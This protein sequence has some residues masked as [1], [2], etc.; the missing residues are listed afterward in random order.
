MAEQE[1]RRM[2]ATYLAS[3]VACLALSDFLG[4][5]AELDNPV[6]RPLPRRTF[7]PDQQVFPLDDPEPCWILV[8]S[9][10]IEIYLDCR[11]ERVPVKRIGRGAIFGEMPQT[12]L[13]MLGTKAIA[14]APSQVVLLNCAALREITTRKP[15]LLYRWAELMGRR[16]FR[17]EKDAALSAFGNIDS[18]LASLLLDLADPRGVIS[19]VTHRE[20]ASML[21]KH[22]ASVSESLAT[23]QAARL[24]HTRRREITLIDTPGLREFET[25][26]LKDPKRRP[27]DKNEKDR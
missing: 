7:R 18:R 2:V 26:C 22:R 4:K 17:L 5:G 16:L 12:G 21:G 14:L 3:R 24:I 20:L 15:K 8:E 10:S 27:G 19:G 11:P 9:G 6:L 1:R 23:M 13:V 25:S